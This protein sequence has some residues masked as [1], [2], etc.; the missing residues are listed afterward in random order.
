MYNNYYISNDSGGYTLT[1]SGGIYEVIDEPEYESYA[2]QCFAGAVKVFESG[3]YESAAEQFRLVVQLSPDDVVVPFTYSQALFAAGNYAHA[4]GV[5]RAA[6]A[7]IPEEEMTIYYP[8]GLYPDEKILNKQVN[9]LEVAVDREPFA[10]D[11]QL[12]LGYQ[13]LGMGQLDK[14]YGPLAEA[15]KDPANTET[16]GRLIDLAISLQQAEEDELS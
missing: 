2:D 13:Y 10:S 14:A 3:S 11:Y 9:R 6:I 7:Q 8:R 4:A 15:A 12:L 1:N 16:A 5:L